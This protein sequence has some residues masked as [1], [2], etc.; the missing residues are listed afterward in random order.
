MFST[1]YIKDYFYSLD[2]FDFKRMENKFVSKALRRRRR[3][4]FKRNY[5]A[6]SSKLISVQTDMQNLI[7]E[8]YGLR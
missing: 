6:L 4:L 1:H 5:T 2:D 8:N 7:V 3:I